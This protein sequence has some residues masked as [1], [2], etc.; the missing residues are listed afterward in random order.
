MCHRGCHVSFMMPRVNTDITCQHTSELYGVE[1]DP[2]ALNVQLEDFF[3]HFDATVV[4]VLRFLQFPEEDI[5]AMAE[6]AKTFDVR[7]WSTE[8]GWMQRTWSGRARRRARDPYVD[9]PDVT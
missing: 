6:A 5:P 9:L 1:R 2:N 4:R 7:R 8:V 3:H